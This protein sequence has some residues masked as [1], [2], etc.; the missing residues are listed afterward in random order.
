[1]NSLTLGCDCLGTIAYLDVDLNT[2][3]GDIF[4]IDRAICIHEEDAGILWKHWDFRTE[5]T[6][7]RRGRKL[8]ISS[9]ATVGNYEY[10]SYWYFDQSGMIE[11]EMKAT[12]IINTSACEPGKPTKYGVEVSPGLQGHIHQ[13]A[14]C[15][16]LEMAVDG[17]GN[18]FVECNTVV[19][20]DDKNPYGNAF[21]QVDTVLK[22][23]MEAARKANPET[24]RYWKVINPNKLNHV[25]K[26]VAY[27]IYPQN[28]LTTYLK[29]NSPSGIRSSFME[30]HVWVTKFDPEERYAAGEFMNHSDGSGGVKQFAAQNRNIENENLV[31]WH[32]F[33]LHHQPRPEDFPVQPCI[34]SGFT[35]MPVGFFDENPANDVAPS[36]NKASKLANGS[37]SCCAHE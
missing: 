10:A 6:E 16:R 18:S 23:E 36:L 34:T 33:G 35:L 14:F 3:T 5:R 20:E 30:N 4:H 25:G 19:E 8:V 7:L 1:T 28:V 31:L 22:T 12:G 21:Y 11:F 26:P 9:I 29:P 13:H 17:P 32:V 2:M 24:Q 15:A 37:S 27:K